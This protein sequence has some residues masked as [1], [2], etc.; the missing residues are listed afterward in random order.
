MINKNLS[1]HRAN[2]IETCYSAIVLQYQIQY[3]LYV[4]VFCTLCSSW[5]QQSFVQEGKMNDTQTLSGVK[6]FIK[7]KG[8][9]TFFEATL[10]GLYDLHHT[11]IHH[12]VSKKGHSPHQT[13]TTLDVYHTM[14]KKGHSP[15]QTST[16]PDIHH[17]MSK[18]GH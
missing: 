1:Y 17:T 15:H 18:I 12:T 8:M 7:V 5:H 13:S 14:S 2:C 16:A 11:D 9:Q 10:M 4:N 3:F 6:C